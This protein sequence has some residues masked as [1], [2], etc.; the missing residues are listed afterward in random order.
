MKRINEYKKLL[1]VESEID[2][3]ELKKTYRSL[4]KEW[5]PDKFQ[6]DDE[7]FAEAELKSQQII[8]GY[9][10]LISI[11]PETKETNLEKYKETT[12][13]SRILDFD[14]K[15]QVLK[16]D[17]SNGDSYE[18]FGVSKKVFQKLIN[19]DIPVRFA[20]R[21]IYESF[22]YRKMKKAAVDA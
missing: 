3:K 13:T 1:S 12:S 11:A 15:G 22:L 5:H 2:L 7:K 14:L 6:A 19:S 18:Y 21:N 10:F 17:F 9:H 8:D 20:K 4:V 16:I